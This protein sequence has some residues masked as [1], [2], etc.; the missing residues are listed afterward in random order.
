MCG[1]CGAVSLSAARV[2]DPSLVHRMIA[3]LRHRGPDGSGSLES[4]TAI[5]GTRRLRV[6]DP[7]PV[8]DQPFSDPRRL[9]WLAC[10]GEIYN[11]HALRQRFPSYPYRSRSDVE[12]IIPL[13]LARGTQALEDLDGMFAIALWDA[14]TRQ[15]TLARDRAGEKPLFYAKI[16]SEI[17]FA[18]EIQALLAHPRLSRELDRIAID[19]LLTVGYVLEPRTMFAHIR[20]VPA[21]TILTATAERQTLRRYWDPTTVPTLST[22]TERDAVR[23]LGR[24]LQEAVSKQL[25]ADVPLGVF[26]SGGV[27][28]AL[29]AAMAAH[30]IGPRRLR[31][32][33]VG[34]RSPG[35]DETR[36]AARLAAALQTPQLVATADPRSLREALDTITATLAEPVADP[37]VLPTYLMARRAR[38]EVTA[39]LSGEGADELFGGYPTYLGHRFA[40][41]VT[42]LPAPLGAVLRAAIRALPPS[43]RKVAVS[44][45][46]KRFVAQLEGDWFERHVRW[47]GTGLPDE[48]RVRRWVRDHRAL[49]AHRN[50]DVLANAMQ[51]DYRTYLRDGLLVK[52]DRA[53]ML[54]S[55]EARA[56]YLDREVSGFAL[57]L[58]S[59]LHVRGVE[60]KSLLKAVASRW[61]APRIVHRRKRG[62]SVPVGAWLNGELGG[63]VDRLLGPERV[64][65]RGILQPALVRRL[66]AEH[67]SARVD[68]ARALWPIL[69]FE[70]WHE[71]WLGG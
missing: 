57:G 36:P 49:V 42:D 28:S 37:A 65:S 31:I 54:A 27:D 20:R 41:S 39:V 67:R 18:S 29:L 48:P 33:T 15:L 40:R 19:D 66:V 69:V 26:S 13:V 2:G 61:L 32:I 4:D 58:P 44:Y 25:L 62:L 8:A 59:A 47:F 11:A 50:G 3:L 38:E 45:I 60:T 51:W 63:E 22:I 56:P 5:F 43:P 7:R 53:T 10:N 34:F 1:I 52:L 30:A 64:A 46:L 14:R 68:H 6:R 71:R 12:P 17:W 24:L 9:L 23:R 21:G 55:L 16:D 35:Y 70:L